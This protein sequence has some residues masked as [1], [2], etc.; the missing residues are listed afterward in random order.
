[1]KSEKT[2]NG[3]TLEYYNEVGNITFYVEGTHDINE[4]YYNVAVNAREDGKGNVVVETTDNYGYDYDNVVRTAIAK[5]SHYNILFDEPILS[6]KKAQDLLY[7][8]R[9]DIDTLI[10]LGESYA[11]F[12][13]AQATHKYLKKAKNALKGLS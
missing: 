5:L 10:A 7:N 1:M 12:Q 11:H 8:V 13:S 4:D 6:P 2:Y 3:L 9:K